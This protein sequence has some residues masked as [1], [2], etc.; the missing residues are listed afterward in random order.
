[1]HEHRLAEEMVASLV[2]AMTDQGGRRVV[3]VTVELS[4]M[5]GE[6]EPA[7]RHGFEEKSEG[8]PIEGAELIVRM[9]APRFRCVECGHEMPAE[10]EPEGCSVCGSLELALAPQPALVIRDVEIELPDE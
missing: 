3:R 9:I 8:T 2:K 4:E 10:G 5:G 6:S 1:M 7:L